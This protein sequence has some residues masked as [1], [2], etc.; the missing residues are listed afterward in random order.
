LGIGG[1]GGGM[2]KAEG[3]RFFACGEESISADEPNRPQNGVPPSPKSR[4]CSSILVAG[5]RLWLPISET[6][7]KDSRYNEIIKYQLVVSSLA[8]V[9]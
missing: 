8:L 5:R 1:V 3:V 4:H 7:D 6:R 9:V 2:G